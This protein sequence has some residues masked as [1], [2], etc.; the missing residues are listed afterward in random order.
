LFV[1]VGVS[2]T[3]IVGAIHTPYDASRRGADPYKQAE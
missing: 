3:R 2:T 1:G